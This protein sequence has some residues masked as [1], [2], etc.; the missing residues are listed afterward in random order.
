MPIW[1][2]IKQKV[3]SVVENLGEST[4]LMF[5]DGFMG[6]KGIA[7]YERFRMKTWFSG[8]FVRKKIF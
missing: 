7:V 2:H 4:T 8:D 5:F 6:K 1:G 3:I